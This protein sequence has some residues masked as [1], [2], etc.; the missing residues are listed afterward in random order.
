MNNIGILKYI[1]EFFKAYEKDHT[2]YIHGEQ[3]KFYKATGLYVIWDIGNEWGCLPKEEINAVTIEGARLTITVTGG[4]EYTFIAKPKTREEVT[5]RIISRIRGKLIRLPYKKE[6]REILHL[7]NELKR[8]N[9]ERNEDTTL[10]E[11]GEEP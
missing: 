9:K 5:E 3:I 10:E 11:Y 6:I 4:K 2:F 8:I 7:L 1:N